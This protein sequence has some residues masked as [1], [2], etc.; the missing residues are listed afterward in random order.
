MRRSGHSPGLVGPD[1]KIRKWRDLTVE[2]L[3]EAFATHQPVCPDCCAKTKQP[4]ATGSRSA[5]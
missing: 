2:D 3:A 5:A 4:P 1:G